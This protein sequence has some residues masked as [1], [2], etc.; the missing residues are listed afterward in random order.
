VKGG[1]LY[2]NSYS[3]IDH[4]KVAAKVTSMKGV[5]WMVSYDDAPE[6]RHLYE[7]VNW[8]RYS[9]G[10]SARKHGVGAEA[11]YFA[12]SLSV[13]KLEGLMVELER[14]SALSL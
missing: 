3:Y 14:S 9:I 4:A 12:P 2:Y 13:P 7:G 10:Y 1:Q 11:M 6:I 8:L 5:K